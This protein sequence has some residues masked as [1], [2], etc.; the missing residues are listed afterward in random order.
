MW[1][2]MKIFKS[3]FFFLIQLMI[4]LKTHFKARLKIQH[5]TRIRLTDVDGFQQKTI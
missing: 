5:Q 3:K 4:H 2:G 1:V